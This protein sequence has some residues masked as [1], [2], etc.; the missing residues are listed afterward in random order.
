M[1]TGEMKL[2]NILLLVLGA[3][4]IGSGW[5][6]IARRRTRTQYGEHEGRTAVRLGWF[7]L[8][9]G[10]LLLLAAL[11]KIPFLKGLGRLFLESET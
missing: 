11:T 5:W 2:L 1:A 8:L 4:L 9:L 6:T 7:W 10:L 3:G